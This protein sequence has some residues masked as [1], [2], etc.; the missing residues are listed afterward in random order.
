MGKRPDEELGPKEWAQIHTKVQTH[1][2]QTKVS[3]T[4]LELAFYSLKDI[5]LIPISFL[6]ESNDINVLIVD[7]DISMRESIS[8]A[9]E[10]AGFKP[11]LASKPAEALSMSKVQQIHAAVIDC[12]LPGKNGVD[13]AAEIREVM[14][15]DD[16]IFF[17]TGI[18]KDKV[19]AAESLKKTKAD[20]F[21][22]KPFDIEELIASIR[23]KV[24]PFLGESKKL[25]LQDLLSKIQFSDEELQEAINHMDQM[26]GFDISFCL[27]A[28]MFSESTGHLNIS[29]AEKRKCILTL[30]GGK[31]REVGSESAFQTINQ[32]LIKQGLLTQDECNEVLEKSERSDFEK[33]LID[34][35][36][37][38]PHA[39]TI[40]KKEQISLELEKIITSWFHQGIIHIREKR[41]SFPM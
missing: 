18:Y 15:N 13:V 16:V 29:D 39:M 24:G 35:N 21:F 14:T 34:N 37:V 38:S 2:S 25:T 33:S 36:W 1:A 32:L 4:F 9:V 27:P 31:I 22:Y 8:K 12:M 28:L 19:F 41:Q 23:E 30:V 17:I 6:M 40:L 3:K 20:R 11:L 5:C 7:D 26:S 10:R